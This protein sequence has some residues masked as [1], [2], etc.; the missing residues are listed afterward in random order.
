MADI[1][2]G[3]QPELDLS[4]DKVVT[5]YKAAAEICNSEFAPAS[6]NWIETRRLVSQLGTSVCSRL[7]F[8]Q[9]MNY[10]CMSGQQLHVTM[11]S[12]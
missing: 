10:M 12:S 1:E 2:N 8:E 6:V 7:A 3:E 11:T 4:D 5:K 9:H